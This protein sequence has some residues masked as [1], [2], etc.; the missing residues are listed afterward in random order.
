MR[1]LMPRHPIVILSYRFHYY[2]F[3]FNIH[4][5]SFHLIVATPIN[6]QVPTRHHVPAPFS[7]LIIHH[8]PMP[9]LRGRRII[10]VFMMLYTLRPSGAGFLLLSARLAR[11]KRCARCALEGAEVTALATC[12]SAMPFLQ[13][14]YVISKHTIVS[15][16]S[17]FALAAS[18]AFRYFF[19]AT[20]G[21][22]R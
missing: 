9:G 6:Y 15:H 10:N 1:V 19:A 4:P 8:A 21:A 2:T 17:A 5:S 14:F 11:Q 13:Q 3:R 22:T 7:H 16:L 20:Y 12:F 18:H